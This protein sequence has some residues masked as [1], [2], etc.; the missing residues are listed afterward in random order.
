MANNNKTFY[1]KVDLEI[2]SFRCD[3]INEAWL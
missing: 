3:D 2:P 1:G